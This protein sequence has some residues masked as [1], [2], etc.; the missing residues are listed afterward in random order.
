[1]NW[2][3]FY[4][5]IHEYWNLH[6]NFKLYIMQNITLLQ[7]SSQKK[8]TSIGHLKALKISDCYHVHPQKIHPKW[9]SKSPKIS[10]FYN[11]CPKDINRNYS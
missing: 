10:Q 7:C 9:Q 5:N 2:G 6:L 8:N 4:Y 3:V 11:V 1:M